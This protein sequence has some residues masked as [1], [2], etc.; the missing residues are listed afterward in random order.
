MVKPVKP[1][2]PAPALRSN[3]DTFSVNAEGTITYMF[4]TFP[5]YTDAL[6]TFV[7]ARAS[8]AE[9]AV[10]TGE[11]AADPTK[12]FHYIRYN[13]AGDGLEPFEIVEPYGAVMWFARSTAPAGWLKANGA[14]VSRTAYAELFTAIGTTF[15]AGDGTTTF[16]LPDLRGEFVRAWDDAKGTDAGRVFGSS[17]ADQA[18][19]VSA[20]KN[21]A[22]GTGSFNLTSTIPEDGTFSTYLKI[23]GDASNSAGTQAG[24]QF[25]K[26]GHETRPRNIA[27]L[28]CI[29]Y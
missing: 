8:E 24:A 4:T 2:A 25:Q 29:R 11:I 6:G 18:N 10:L 13:A 15:G 14:A 1:T 19:S 16:N 7:D 26:H 5:D 20:W 28:A 12:A 21:T 3:P 22:G 23:A 27:L 17:Q 9:T